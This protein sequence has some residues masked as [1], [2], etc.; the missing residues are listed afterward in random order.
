MGIIGKS[1]QRISHSD[2]LFNSVIMGPRYEYLNIET[3]IFNVDFY[4]GTV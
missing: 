1:E 2:F 4:L 3:A